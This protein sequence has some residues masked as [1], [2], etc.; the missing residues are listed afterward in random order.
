[1]PATGQIAQHATG[2]GNTGNASKSDTQR[3]PIAIGAGR[4]LPANFYYMDAN[5][6][7]AEDELP[8]FQAIRCLCDFDDGFRA[9]CQRL[10]VKIVSEGQI[11]SAKSGSIMAFDDSIMAK[12]MS[13]WEAWTLAAILRP[14]LLHMMMPENQSMHGTRRPGSL[15]PRFFGAYVHISSLDPTGVL[16]ARKLFVIM[17][18]V[19]SGLPVGDDTSGLSFEKFDLKGSADDRKQRAEGLELMDFDLLR[20]DRKFIPIDPS[21][22]EEFL[23]QLSR[24]VDFLMSQHMP[25]DPTGSL[26]YSSI[27][28]ACRTNPGLMDYS[29]LVGLIPLGILQKQPSQMSWR[30]EVLD[31]QTFGSSTLPPERWRS[32]VK[33][34]IAFVGL[35]DILQFWTPQKQF[36]RHLKL[37]M[38]KEQNDGGEFH[39]E[40]LDT[41]APGPYGRRFFNFVRE[42]F[43]PGS[44]LAS[45]PHMHNGDWSQVISKQIQCLPE[46]QMME[47]SRRQRATTKIERQD[48]DEF[49]AQS[50]VE[51]QF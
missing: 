28:E 34:A 14:Y 6:Q 24:D 10:L 21:E 17:G 47:A 20:C 1:M 41:V 50:A 2:S 42:V 32:E 35:I 46:E 31:A 8:E 37:A 13:T 27:P 25:T 12:S 45:L 7:A 5:G 4:E 49:A 23:A 40:I 51:T 33:E 22:G 15:L 11:S 29:L 26:E 9:S 16:E 48:S 39:G 18:N 38:G 19:F 43:S 44:W 36:A 3:L 30:L